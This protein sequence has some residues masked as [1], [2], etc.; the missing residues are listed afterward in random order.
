MY[1]LAAKTPLEMLPKWEH[2]VPLPRG[3]TYPVRLDFPVWIVDFGRRE[4]ERIIL[5]EQDGCHG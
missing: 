1:E 5:E 3:M 4:V 2:F